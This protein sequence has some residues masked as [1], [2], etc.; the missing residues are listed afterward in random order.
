M[1]Y[2]N[3]MKQLEV[4]SLSKSF[5][6]AAAVLNEIDFQLNSGEFLVI[7]GPSG[8]GKTTLLRIIA[9][10]ESADIGQVFIKGRDVTEVEPKNRDVAMVFQ[11]YALY[12]HMT[13]FD[14]LSFA[15][16]V[17]KLSKP[18]IKDK[19]TRTA[20]M[21]GLEPYLE[22]KPKQ[23]SGGQRQRVALGRAIVRNPALFLFDEP[24]SNLDAELRSQMRFELLSLHRRLRATSV[25]VTHD[26][27]EAMSLADKIIILNKGNKIGPS[28]PRELYDNPPDTFVAGFL[29]NPGMNL[30]SGAIGESSKSVKLDSDVILPIESG[31]QAGSPIVFGFR[32]EHCR[33]SP[34]GILPG[35]VE[36]IEDSGKEYILKL[37]GPNN[38]RYYCMSQVKAEIGDTISLSIDMFYLFDQ[39]NNKLISAFR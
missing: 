39:R 24:L 23:L 18:E 11:N 31:I 15:L 22:R 21:L 32:P 1:I 6:G 8:C 4:K 3:K 7:L 34:E 19:V 30:I 14:N 25:Y 13:V 36:G 17:R 5:N 35:E 20:A 38:T 9:G 26:Q 28:A 10:L 16:K 2:I 27:I 33:P 12:P 29:G 37:K